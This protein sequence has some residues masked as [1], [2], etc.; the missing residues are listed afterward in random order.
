MVEPVTQTNDMSG[1]WVD[2]L[3]PLKADLTLDAA[4]FCAHVRNLSAKG[5]AHFTVFGFAG[6][7]PCF[8]NS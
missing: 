4:H 2:V 5:L 7:G 8:S 1:V 6:E 3:T